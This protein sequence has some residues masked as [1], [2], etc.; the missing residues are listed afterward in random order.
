MK[1]R[2]EFIFKKNNTWL[3]EISFSFWVNFISVFI[4]LSVTLNLLSVILT[5]QNYWRVWLNSDNI[6][7]HHHIPHGKCSTV[8]RKELQKQKK[9]EHAKKRKSMCHR[10]QIVKYRVK[11]RVRQI[12]FR[13]FLNFSTFSFHFLIKFLW[14]YLLNLSFNPF[15][16]IANWAGIA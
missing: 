2:S 16:P 1:M 12:I 13:D 6:I 14:V 15:R 9:K 10:W 7:E 5:I 3:F 8:E 4:W 11:K